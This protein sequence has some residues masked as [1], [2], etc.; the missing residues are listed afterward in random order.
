MKKVNLYVGILATAI[1]ILLFYR[2]FQ[3]E[4]LQWLI[5]AM[6]ILN[7]AFFNLQKYFLLD[8]KLFLNVITL[9]VNI[10]IASLA[11]IQYFQTM[12]FMWLIVGILFTIVA[13]I[14]IKNVLKK[15]KNQIE[16][17]SKA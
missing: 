12:K 4:D 14:D 15:N 10:G 8:S 13:C 11:L 2:Y 17:I 5:S 7:I 9:V 1:T 3:K 16:N 6:V